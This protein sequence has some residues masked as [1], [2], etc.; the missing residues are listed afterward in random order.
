[1]DLVSFRQDFEYNVQRRK[2]PATSTWSKV[3]IAGIDFETKDGFPH[4]M[5]WTVWNVE[6]QEWKNKLHISR[7]C[8]RKR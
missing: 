1:M 2:R 6:E 7:R 4:I 8:Q 5:T 3:D